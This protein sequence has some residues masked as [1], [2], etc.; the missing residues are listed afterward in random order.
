MNIKSVA[1]LFGTNLKHDLR[2]G[3]W[4]KVLIYV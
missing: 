3:T 4:H 2:Y 1:I